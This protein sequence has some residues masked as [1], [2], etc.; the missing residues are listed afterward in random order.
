MRYKLI[1]PEH[2]KS[3]YSTWEQAHEINKILKMYISKKDVIT[4]ATACIGGNSIFFHRDFKSVNSVEKDQYTFYT[5]RKNTAFP[6]CKH[7]NCSY[8]HLMYVLRQ[9]L[10]FLD[11]PWGGTDYKKTKSIDLFLDNVNVVDIINSLYHNTRYIAMK[12][13]NNYNL[14]KLDK[15]FWDWKIYPINSNKKNI[16]NLIIFYK[17]I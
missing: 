7:Y 9:D 17:R 1:V 14:D 4:D 2:L 3:I 15:N 10:V 12:I 5:L 13:P 11:P 8:L 6:N 16:F